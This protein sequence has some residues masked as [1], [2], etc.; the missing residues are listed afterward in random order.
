MHVC[1]CKPQ[2][3]SA[4]AQGPAP[5]LV[6]RHFPNPIPQ[7]PHNFRRLR[8]DAGVL[9]ATNMDAGAEVEVPLLKV[10]RP[11]TVQLPTSSV[12]RAIADAKTG[13][14]DIEELAS[15]TLLFSP[16]RRCR[17]GRLPCGRR[18]PP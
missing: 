3:V 2:A 9:R 14:V 4:P 16:I 8:T 17:G 13:S 10:I 6:D 7:K 1:M 18:G 5:L 12:I 11:G 15:E